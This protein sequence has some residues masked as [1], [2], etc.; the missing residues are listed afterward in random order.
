M[1]AMQLAIK[2]LKTQANNAEDNYR[3]ALAYSRAIGYA[4]VY[5]EQAKAEWETILAA[6]AELEAK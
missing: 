6:I 2:A 1:T 4:T 5:V 3:R